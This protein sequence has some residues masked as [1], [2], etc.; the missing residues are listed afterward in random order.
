M[1]GA[2]LTRCCHS[3]TQEKFKIDMEDN[4][5]YKEKKSRK[6]EDQ[7][8]KKNA[9]KGLTY[10]YAYS[11]GGKDRKRCTGHAGCEGAE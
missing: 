6:V 8:E 7:E 1:F 11:D 9:G 4:S 3:R 10:L 5:L 2:T